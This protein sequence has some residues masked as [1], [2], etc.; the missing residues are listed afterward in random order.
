MKTKYLIDEI[1]EGRRPYT[2]SSKETPGMWERTLLGQAGE[3]GFRETAGNY[4]QFTDFMAQHQWQL[5]ELGIFG[6]WMMKSGIDPRFSRDI[7]DSY[8]KD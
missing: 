3:L 6:D 2:P 1:Q 5:E 4:E 8:L 7:L